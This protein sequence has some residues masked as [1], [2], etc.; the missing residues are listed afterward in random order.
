MG[1]PSNQRLIAIAT[2]VIIALLGCI[3][4]LIYDKVNKDKLIKQ[5]SAEL[6]S[7]EKLQAQLE[8][9]YYQ[10]LADLEEMR[11]TNDELN[12]LIETQKG[13]LKTQKDRISGL[14]KNSKDLEVARTEIAKLKANAEKYLAEITTL[15][16]ENTALTSRNVRLTSEKDSLS[17]E[18]VSRTQENVELTEARAQL[19]SE[20]ET[21]EQEKSALSKKVNV[22][23]V[24]KIQDIDVSGYKLKN[25]G[26]ESEARKAKTIDGLKICFTALDNVITPPGNERF[27]VRVIN[28]IGE[29]MTTNVS[30]ASVVT[31][32]NTGEEVLYTQYSDVN[33]EQKEQNICMN[34]QPELAFN[35]GQ[36]T[37]EVYNKGFLAGMSTV[38]LK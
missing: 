35:T 4:Y 7:T 20:K 22:A 29:T 12:A 16:E 26:K 23:S 27:F 9:E 2:V 21:L 3:G 6:I 34:W 32:P 31:N 37:V 36:Y 19:T 10:A 15:R 30:G 18:V 13:E 38:N 33:Y 17:Q 25:S 11:G 14:L 5:Y 24:I 8:K 28:P 1:N